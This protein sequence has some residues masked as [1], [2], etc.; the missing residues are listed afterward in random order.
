MTLRDTPNSS[1]SFRSVGSLDPAAKAA[2]E[3]SRRRRRVISR[4]VVCVSL[5]PVDRALRATFLVRFAILVEPLKLI[6]D[7]KWTNMLKR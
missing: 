4:E 3:N 2:E 7:N 1:A 6:I 5:D